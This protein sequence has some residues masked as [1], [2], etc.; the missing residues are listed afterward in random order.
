MDDVDYVLGRLGPRFT[1]A[2]M[3]V[4]LSQLGNHV[5]TR[6][7]ARRTIGQ[8]RRIAER[9]YGVLFESDTQ[10]SER[11]LLPSMSAESKGMEDA[12]FV[13]FSDED[14]TV[15]YYASYTAY[16][17]TDIGQQL[18][19]TKDFVHFT[20]SPLV[21]AAAANK[22]LA[23][24]P[25]RIGGRFA[26]LSRS[27]RETNTITF[28]TNLRRWEEALT[29]QEPTRS[30][31]VL[32]LGNCGAPI[33]TD[34]GWLVLTHGV[35]PMRTYSIGAILLD[36]DDPTRIIGRL[37][38]PLLSPSREEQDGYVPNVVYSCGALLHAGTL[39][40]PYG[41]GDSAIGVATVPLDELLTALRATPD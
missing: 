15:T 27:D 37:H 9:S 7:Q 34:V 18:L 35:G 3:E 19:E 32:Q 29:C 22:G 25:R 5:A 6:K 12:R 2:E 4:R 38:E 24:F 30:W 14:A 36:L 28:S 8:I 31:E 39:V 40:L 11:V 23:L 21:G 17:G 33:E 26:A 13:R 10:L 16:N 41:V 1:S 20:S